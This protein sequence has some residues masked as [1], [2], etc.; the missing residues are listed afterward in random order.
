MGDSDSRN[1]SDCRNNSDSRNSTQGSLFFQLFAPFVL[2]IPTV[3]MGDSDSRNWRFRQSESAPGPDCRQPGP[4]LRQPAPPHSIVR[5]ITENAFLPRRNGGWGGAGYRRIPDFTPW[6]TNG[7][8]HVKNPLIF[9]KFGKTLKKC[10]LELATSFSI[11]IGRRR[12]YRQTTQLIELSR[13][14][15]VSSSKNQN[16]RFLEL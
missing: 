11:L 7:F 14:A 16:R 4:P 1:D 5:K 6:K 12:D 2:P 15:V 9:E 10:Q 3:G 13:L 8:R